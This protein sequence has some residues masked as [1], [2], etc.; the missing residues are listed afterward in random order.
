MFTT[1]ELTRDIGTTVIGADAV[2]H[3]LIDKIGGIGEAIAELNRRIDER[4]KQGGGM[5]Q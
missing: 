2:K 4:K 3:G 1:G 5:L